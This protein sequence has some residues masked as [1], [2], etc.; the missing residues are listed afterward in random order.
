MR[1]ANG[2]L[3][4]NV[5]HGQR[6][7]LQAQQIYLADLE[8]ARIGG[9]VWHM[10]GG[11]TL[12]FDRKVLIDKRSPFIGMTLEADLVLVG[13]GSE[14]MGLFR[15]MG[16]VTIAANEKSLIDAVPEG[17]AELCLLHG[18]AAVAQSWLA[19]L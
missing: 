17:T 4:R 9:S 13:S 5:T 14:L 11:A 10:T 19:V 3:R 6:V 8:Q 15:T 2:R 12:A 16:I 7:A 18:V 1:R